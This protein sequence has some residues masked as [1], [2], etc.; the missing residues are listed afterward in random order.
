MNYTIYIRKRNWDR[1]QSEPNKADLINKLLESHYTEERNPYL[2][3]LEYD[4]VRKVIYDPETGETF[5][6]IVDNGKVLS[7][8]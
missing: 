8:E 4:T 2:D 6:G 7:I 1:F 5:K 3:T